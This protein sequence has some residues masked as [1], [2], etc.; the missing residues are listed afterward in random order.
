MP[1][2]PRI[3]EQKRLYRANKKASGERRISVYIPNELHQL[4]CDEQFEKGYANLGVALANILTEWRG[5]T[6]ED[7]LPHSSNE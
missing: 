4:I 1:L 7:N 2:D 5:Y 6:N 3:L